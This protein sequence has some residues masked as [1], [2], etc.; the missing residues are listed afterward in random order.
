MFGA[1]MIGRRWQAHL[2]RV[3]CVDSTAACLDAAAVA[4]VTMAAAAAAVVVM[5]VKVGM[6]EFVVV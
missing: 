6:V 4:G 3:H 5:V 1:D 2:G